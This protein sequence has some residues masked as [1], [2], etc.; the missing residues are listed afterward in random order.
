M[1]EIMKVRGKFN[2]TIPKKLRK[3][4]PIKVGQLIEI[5]LEDDKLIL[6]PIA[7]DPPS[8]LEEIIGKIRPE[9][10]RTQAEETILKEAKSSLAKKIEQR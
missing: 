10:I 4:L 2:V 8:R 3:S 7:E 9:D 6:K 1:Q 5:K